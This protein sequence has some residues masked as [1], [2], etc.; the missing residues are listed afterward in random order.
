MS[1]YA[2]DPDV[3]A[4]FE[5]AGPDLVFSPAVITSDDVTAEWLAAAVDDKRTLRVHLYGLTV[6]NHPLRLVVP[7][8]NDVHLG[9]IT[10]Q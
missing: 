1:L 4:D 6:G 7:G 9:T 8:G 5:V 3:H 2:D 10:L